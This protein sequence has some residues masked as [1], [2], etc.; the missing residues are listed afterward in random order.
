MLLPS[1]FVGTRQSTLDILF[2]LLLLRG[3]IATS[4]L[5]EDIKFSLG[6]FITRRM[7]I[8]LRSAVV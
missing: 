6:L 8:Y 2:E 7:R 5:F 3:Q 4:G 1:L